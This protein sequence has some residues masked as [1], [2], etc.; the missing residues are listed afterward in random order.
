[1]VLVNNINY[2]RNYKLGKVIVVT[3]KGASSRG[4]TCY[5]FFFLKEKHRKKIIKK[6]LKRLFSL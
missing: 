3:N 1:M 4:Y 5:H 6:M 2:L